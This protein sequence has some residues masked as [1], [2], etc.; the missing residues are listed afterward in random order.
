MV[1]LKEKNAYVI[2]NDSRFQFL[3]VQ[4]KVLDESGDRY[5]K[6]VSIP[7]GS[8]KSTTRNQCVICFAHVSIPNGSIKRQTEANKNL[9]DYGSFNS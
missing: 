2:N 9:A 6:A 4:L 7:N 5:F 8:I 3:M 1:Q